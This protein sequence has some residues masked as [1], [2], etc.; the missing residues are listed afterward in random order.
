[1]AV[2]IQ[3]SLPLGD[4]VDSVDDSNQL[5]MVLG[6]SSKSKEIILGQEKGD[7]VVED[8]V[9]DVCSEDAF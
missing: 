3:I 7:D 2:S 9:S 5:A 8:W 4:V 6:L 1:M